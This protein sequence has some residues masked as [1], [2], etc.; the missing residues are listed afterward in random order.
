MDL[1]VRAVD[2]ILRRAPTLFV[3]NAGR[4]ALIHVAVANALL[5]DLLPSASKDGLSFGDEAAERDPLLSQLFQSPAGFNAIAEGEKTIV[6]GDRGSGKSA[7]CRR[8]AEFGSGIPRTHTVPICDPWAH[9]ER[10]LP[11][12]AGPHSADQLRG[13]WLLAIAA[14]VADAL[15]VRSA[16]TPEHRKQADVL[17]QLFGLTSTDRRA[18]HRA[19][20]L[21][22]KVIFGTK[23]EVSVGPIK[24]DL[25]LPEGILSSAHRV[26]LEDFLNACNAVL[27]AASAKV[28]VL[29]DQTD[30]I[31]KYERARQ[32]AV[33]Q[34]LFLA[35]S[36]LS[37]L[38]HIRAILFVRSDLFETYDLQEKNK[39]VSRTVR[40]RWE[41]GELLK[42]MASRVL[43]NPQFTSLRQ[44]LGFEQHTLRDAQVPYALNLVLPRTVEGQ[45]RLQWLI[46]SLKNGNGQISP[47]QV[48]LLLNLAATYQAARRPGI[49]VFAEASL[50]SALGEL[51]DLW[52]KE[53]LDDFRVA[54]TLVR[55]CRAGRVM[56]LDADDLKRMIDSDEGSPS[57]QVDLLE[58]L[59]FLERVVVKEGG[60]HTRR[61][62]IPRLYTRSWER[63]DSA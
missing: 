51:S 55:N 20:R 40:L 56:D 4:F 30:E 46:D 2:S 16:L 58:R 18:V 5:D 59:G 50:T 17:R 54:R 32:Q 28:L 48:V 25:S 7:I 36:H 42:L 11:A 47:R 12:S 24:I 6:V 33:F 29:I 19:F 8:L 43:A 34:G 3:F 37:R 9:L 63:A 14:H 23:L 49:P 41:L 39:L 38:S 10:V 26:D 31:F 62:R 53:V 15:V 35:E 52:Y 1:P 44:L 27:K 61:F 45:E 13:A 22:L 60:S 21:L 57:E